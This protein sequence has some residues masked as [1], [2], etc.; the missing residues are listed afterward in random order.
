MTR[1][2]IAR[3]PEDQTEL[4]C[5]GEQIKLALLSVTAIV[6]RQRLSANRRHASCTSIC[7]HHHRWAGDVTRLYEAQIEL[8][9]EGK[10][11]NYQEID[12][13]RGESA[14]VDSDTCRYAVN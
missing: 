11:K 3:G 13:E 9:E 6:A 7:A 14:Q 4:H 10:S 5:G 2:K 1:G 8:E 12:S